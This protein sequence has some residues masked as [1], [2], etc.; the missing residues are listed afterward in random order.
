MYPFISVMHLNNVMGVFRLVVY[1]QSNGG[2]NT[3]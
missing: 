1:L 3:G 2:H